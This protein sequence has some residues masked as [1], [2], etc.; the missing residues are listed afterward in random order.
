VFGLAYLL[1]I[2][3]MPRIRN[4]KDLI[5]FRPT[6]AAKYTHIDSLFGDAIDWDIIQNHWADLMRVVLSIRAG[7]IS[8]AVLLRKLGNNS[9]KNKLY[10]AFRELGRVIRTEFLL[11]YISEMEL[12]QQITALTNK[13]EAYNGFAK[14]SFFG[15]EGV[16]ADNDPEEQEKAIKYNDLVANA[17]ILHNVVD[18]TCVLRTLIDEGYQVKRDDV[19][20]CSPYITRQIKR[21]GDYDVDLNVIP[22]HPV[23]ELVLHP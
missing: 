2:D 9:R 8:S 22:A 18:M 19:A 17:I 11:R 15:G 20:S 6:K 5:F 13:V 4:W 16:I 10:E 1:G 14:W 12:R 23:Q 3:L 7:V 21:F